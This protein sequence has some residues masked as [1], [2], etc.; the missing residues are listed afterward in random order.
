MTNTPVH[1][2]WRQEPVIRPPVGGAQ[3]NTPSL[4]RASRQGATGEMGEGGGAAV[5][6]MSPPLSGSVGCGCR[7][8][9]AGGLSQRD[10]PRGGEGG[11][12]GVTLDDELGDGQNVHRVNEM[13]LSTN[14]ERI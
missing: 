8:G 3:R 5:T 9:T 10:A 13:V 2:L 11:G 12:D 7:C 4:P 14:A 6:E 1:I